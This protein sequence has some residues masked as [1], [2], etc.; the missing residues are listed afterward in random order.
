MK[1]MKKGVAFALAAAMVLGMAGCGDST[2][3]GNPSETKGGSSGSS[4]D[5][6][7]SDANSGG[8]TTINIRLMNDV[9]NVDKILDVYY[10]ETKD[11]PVLSKIKLNITSVAGA[12]YKDKLTLAITAQEDYDLMFC[13][14]WH[15]LNDF[16]KDGSFKDLSSYFNN[17]DYPGLKAGFTEDF[18]SANSIDGK[19]YYVPLGEGYGDIRGVVYRE[20]LRKKYDC[21]EITDWDTYEAYLKT[22]NEHL[23]DEGLINAWGVTSSQGLGQM[24]D[25]QEALRNSIINYTAG[26]PFY[27]SFS[28]DGKTINGI[29]TI[30]DD[31]GMFANFPEGFQYNFVDEAYEEIPYW[32]ENYGNTDCVSTQDDIGAMF[33]AGMYAATY[34][35]LSEWVSRA[36]NIE[37][38][39]PGAELSF[40][41]FD[42][43]M[44]NCEPGAIY[45]EMKSG[46]T[47]VAPAWSTKTD[48]VMAFLDWMF[49]SK[50]HHDLFQFGIEGEDWEA[51]GDNAY[52]PLDID[53]SMK[54]TMPSYAFTSNPNYVRFS[55]KA[56]ENPTV[57]KLL[58]YQY[59]SEAC[60]MLPVTG[61]VFDSANVETE[62]ATLSALY[63]DFKGAWGAYGDAVTAE[64]TQ[65]NADAK[66]AG[67]EKVRAELQSQLQAYIDSQN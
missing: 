40:F 35:T 49:A 60:T 30:G 24:L 33:D 46:N 62:V 41:A 58:N 8:E 31:D 3:A 29:T 53:E 50:E 32:I 55:Y 36:N 51:I 61:F 15:G 43:K 48:E 1:A 34:A 23:D 17:D 6:V 9:I 44:R 21:A 39:C 27:V 14:S 22:M 59:S 57:E 10:E 47:L 64:M 52:K 16:V 37:T 63:A 66:D 4:T 2:G 13:G 5:S 65:L 7:S 26:M 45:S 18:L 11:D 19:T 28:D 12:D 42:D 67:L 20:D 56:L 54:Y 38:N 25:F